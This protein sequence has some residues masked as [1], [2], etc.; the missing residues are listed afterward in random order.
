MYYWADNNKMTLFL[1]GAT[2][3]TNANATHTQKRKPIYEMDLVKGIDIGSNRSSL[4]LRG[5]ERER[6]GPFVLSEGGENESRESSP[7]HLAT[8]PSV[9]KNERHVLVPFPRAK[10]SPRSPPSDGENLWWGTLFSFFYASWV[11]TYESSS[12]SASFLG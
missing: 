2:A 8:P 3:G 9:P 11:P 12:S 6:S 5:R 7:L 1:V 4:L 10:N